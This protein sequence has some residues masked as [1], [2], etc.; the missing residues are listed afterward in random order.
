MIFVIVGMH[1]E[2]FERLVKKMD[3]IAGTIDEEVIIQIGNTKYI[4]KNAKYFTFKDKDSEI[5]DLIKNARVVVCQGA[6]SV[7][8]SLTLG[9]PVIAVPRLQ[10][11]GEHLNDHQLYFVN[12]LK[13]SDLL[14]VVESVDD[15]AL[16]LSSNGLK[17][18]RIIENEELITAIK[19]YINGMDKRH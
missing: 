8:D 19:G 2:G 12:K 11:Y 7:I 4:P 1:F 17:A 6:M 14:Q 18:G 10:R 13:E 9:T 5:K 3:E 15:L 16:L